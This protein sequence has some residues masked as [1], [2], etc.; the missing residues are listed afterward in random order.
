MPTKK[1]KYVV[2][3]VYRSTFDLIYSDIPTDYKAL[4]LKLVRKIYLRTRVKPPRYYKLF[5]CKKCKKPLIPGY[6]AVYR[7]RSRPYK[8]IS[9]KCLECGHVY[10]YGYAKSTK[11]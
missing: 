9:V 2:N 10:R 5:Y 11:D 7:V 1:K 6:N 4:N 8:N 3:D